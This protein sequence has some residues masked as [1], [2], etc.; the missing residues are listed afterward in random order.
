M[1]APALRRLFAAVLATSLL[2]GVSAPALAA[3]P[4]SGELNQTLPRHTPCAGTVIAPVQS[5]PPDSTRAPVP[6]APSQNSQRTC[7][8]IERAPASPLASVISHSV[9]KVSEAGR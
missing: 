3:T 9:R 4:S 8:F 2:I 1:H 6:T 7:R 5:N